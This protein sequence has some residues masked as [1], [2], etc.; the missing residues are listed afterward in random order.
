MAVGIANGI[1]GP[2]TSCH[3]SGKDS[4]RLRD[5]SNQVLNNIYS[6]YEFNKQIGVSGDLV[7]DIGTWDPKA[8]ILDATYS[9][10]L[11]KFGKKLIKVI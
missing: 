7:Q 6:E 10:E 8:F 11:K 9:E 3:S 5:I 1:T 2:T 4:D